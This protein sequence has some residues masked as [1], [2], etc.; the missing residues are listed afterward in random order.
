MKTQATVFHVKEPD[1]G[2]KTP[3]PSFP[4]AF[5]EIAKVEVEGGSVE[6]RL[7]CAFRLTNHIDHDWRLNQ[8]ITMVKKGPVRSTS[9]GDVVSLN[10]VAYRVA[11]FGFNRI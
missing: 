6:A 7:E 4:E 11:A 3:Q 9:V 5:E 1:F 10:G 2:T 8:G